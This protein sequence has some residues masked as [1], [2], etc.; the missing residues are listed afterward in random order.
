MRTLADKVAAPNVSGTVSHK[1]QQ[2]IAGCETHQIDIVAIQEHRCATDELIHYEFLKPRW[3]FAYPNASSIY[4][5]G[6]LYNK[7]I[8]DCLAIIDKISERIIM[9]RLQGNPKTV[10][11]CAY[12]PTEATKD[13][14]V[15]DKFYDD[16][17]NAIRSIPPHTVIIAA[18][19]FN[20][21]IGKASH[22]TSPR[23]VGEH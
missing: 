1:L 16:L 11:I 18:G 23:V 19:D 8:A 22:V 21:R 4:G 6:L 17:E 3:T 15:K 5:V 2:I 20:A 7:R 14:S 13:E 10:I 12:A 9:A